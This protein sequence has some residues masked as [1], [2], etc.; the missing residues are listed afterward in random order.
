[1][2]KEQPQGATGNTPVV[3]PIGS[4]SATF[5]KDLIEKGLMRRAAM[6]P[7][8]DALLE[9]AS[10]TEF[11][12]FNAGFNCALLRVAGMIAAMEEAHAKLMKQEAKPAPSH[13]SEPPEDVPRQW[14]VK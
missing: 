3:T 7:D 8:A 13:P 2:N 4:D 11:Q 12:S 9:G 1:M 14:N 6:S 5:I 10:P